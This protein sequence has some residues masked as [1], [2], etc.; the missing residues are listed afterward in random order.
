MEP[1]RT[2]SVLTGEVAIQIGEWPGDA[3]TILG[4]H[5]L[6]ANLRCYEYIASG[7][8]GHHRLLAMDLRGRGLSDKPA[9]GYSLEHHCRDI[10]AVLDGLGLPKAVVM[11][12]SLGAYIGLAFAAWYPDKTAGLILL[13]GGAELSP[14][15]WVKVAAGIQASVDRLGKVL[16]S[17]EAY[18]DLARRAP[19][20]RP[21]NQGLESYFRYDAQV[22][23]GGVRSRVN[24]ENVAEERVNLAKVSPSQLHPLV[25]CPVLILRAAKGMLG[26]DELLLPGDALENMLKAMP[27]ARVVDLPDSD[28]FSLVFQ[29]NPARDRAILD[30]LDGVA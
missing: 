6:T 20:S 23:P 13:D 18:L 9:T 8:D 24:P 27:Q 17:L 14:P 1:V 2:F 5:G 30:F 28:H 15:Q 29:P 11:G 12:H 10:K 7:L 21:W 3:Q 22:V 16:P 19:Y 26:D 25:K 4:L